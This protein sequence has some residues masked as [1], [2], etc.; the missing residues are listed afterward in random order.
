[1]AIDLDFRRATGF[2][3]PLRETPFREGKAMQS[4]ASL[5][6][7]PEQ[8]L[9]SV[10]DETWEAVKQHYPGDPQSIEVER[11]RVANAVLAAWREGA[12]D[13]KAASIE[14][15]KRWPLA[16]GPKNSSL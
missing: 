6:L 9:R 2:Y 7:G 13:L 3:Y 8:L 4:R 1:V 10:F 14:T 15:M 11:L 16:F 12:S 5:V